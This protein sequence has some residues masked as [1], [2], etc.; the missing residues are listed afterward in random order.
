MFQPVQWPCVM[1][2]L[3]GLR[4]SFINYLFFFSLDIPTYGSN[5]LGGWRTRTIK[6]LRVD[7]YIGMWVGTRHFSKP[8]TFVQVINRLAFMYKS[9]YWAWQKN[10]R[11]AATP[12]PHHPQKEGG[13][14]QRSKKVGRVITW[15]PR[16]CMAASFQLNRTFFFSLPFRHYVRSYS[17]R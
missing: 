4:D 16:P 7:I 5:R 15:R 11:E 9:I 12:T 10:Q 6:E 3:T 1:V 17:F 8:I 13:I 2:E 14:L